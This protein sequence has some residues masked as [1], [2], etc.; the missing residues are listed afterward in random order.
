MSHAYPAG[1]ALTIVVVMFIG[2]AT[3]S[4]SVFN[5]LTVGPIS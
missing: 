1:S 5:D 2:S 4:S 3:W